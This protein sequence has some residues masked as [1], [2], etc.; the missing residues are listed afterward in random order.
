MPSR[1]TVVVHYHI[2]KNAGTTLDSVLG[3]ALGPAYSFEQEDPDS[4]LHAEDLAA[5]LNARPEIRYVTSHALRPPRPSIPGCH[6]V[7]VVFLRHPV[8][9]FR[10]MYDFHR[11]GGGGGRAEEAAKRFHMRDFAAWLAVEAPWNF[12]DPQTSMMG[13]SGDFFHPPV[14]PMFETAWRRVQGVRVLGTVELLRESLGYANVCLRGVL[15]SLDLLAEPI[16]SLNVSAARHP[17]LEGRTRAV[18]DA[19]GNS[20]FD[21]L[22]EALQF[23]MRLWELATAEVQRR[24][25]LVASWRL[26]PAGSP[27]HPERQLV[28]ADHV[29]GDRADR[30][31]NPQPLGTH[32]RSLPQSRMIPPGRG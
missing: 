25:R 4:S 5:L 8:D 10:S 7:D 12:F 28:M 22:L 6:V 26:A 13:N 16:A 11:S 31:T 29:T 23:D 24:H 18:R 9:R 27:S 14:E 20:R 2:F 15:P 21:T 1:R 32:V 3:R 19:L 30:N 17:T